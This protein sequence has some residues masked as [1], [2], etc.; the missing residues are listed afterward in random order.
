MLG[1]LFG[2]IGAG[3]LG[4]VIAVLIRF[5]DIPVHTALGTSMAVM[6]ITVIS[7]TVSHFREGNVEI[8]EGLSIGIFGAIGSFLGTHGAQIIS[9]DSLTYFTGGLLYFAAFTM[10]MK[11]RIKEKGKTADPSGFVYIARIALI[12]LITGGMTGLFGI[13]TTAF[14]QVALLVF[15]GMSLQ[16]AAGT[17]MMISL[18]I[19]AFGTI[20]FYQA[21]FIDG[22]LLLKVVTGTII[23]SY[24]GAMF[25]NRAP[26]SLLRWAMIGT[27]IVAATLL[28]TG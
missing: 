14:I 23:G 1:T 7:G 27:P 2:F 15:C 10:W 13:G 19:G 17:T 3:G 4:F 16:K 26:Q 18:P 25:T 8:R 9:A 5:F 11:T 12:G 24:I 28:V 22:I 20:G 21:G 6:A